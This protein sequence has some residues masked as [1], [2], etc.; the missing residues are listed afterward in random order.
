VEN[1]DHLKDFP[2]SAG[3]RLEEANNAR[4]VANP[5]A[6]LTR[7][8]IPGDDEGGAEGVRPHHRQVDIPLGSR[9]FQP[10]TWLIL[11]RQPKEHLRPPDS[12][13]QMLRGR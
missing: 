12:V 1:R 8:V 10:V 3:A 13:D 9:K 11:L 2:G 4:R 5:R 7:P 6:L